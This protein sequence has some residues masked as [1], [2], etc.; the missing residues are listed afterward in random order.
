MPLR[1]YCAQ[2]NQSFN[3]EKHKYRENKVLY[4]QIKGNI[5]W[6]LRFTTNTLSNRSSDKLSWRHALTY[7]AKT[8]LY[9]HSF[10]VFAFFFLQYNWLQLRKTKNKWQNVSQRYDQRRQENTSAYLTALSNRTVKN[11]GKRVDAGGKKLNVYI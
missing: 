5:L 3:D 11:V 4:L 7:I 9:S 1:R 8:H 6:L 2:T 10:F